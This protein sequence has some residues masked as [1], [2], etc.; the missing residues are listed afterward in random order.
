MD[1]STKSGANVTSVHGLKPPVDSPAASHSSETRAQ[2]Y[3]RRRETPEDAPPSMSTENAAA[4][5]DR[6]RDE[7]LAMFAHELRNAIAP[8]ANAL[9]T[10]QLDRRMDGPVHRRARM[11]IER[12][13]AHLTHLAD[14]LQEVSSNGNAGMRLRHD[15]VDLRAVVQRSVEAVMSAYA[16]RGHQVNVDCPREPILVDADAI[17]LEQVAVNV[18]SNAAKYTPNGGT[19]TVTVA[20]ILDQAVLRVSDTGIGIPAEMLSRVFDLFTRAEDAAGHA[21]DGLGI[22]LNVVKR[23]V[24]LHHGTVVALS[25]GPGKGTEFVVSL[26]LRP[27][28]A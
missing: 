25:D 2:R 7:F 18:L 27:S 8:V 9:A 17:K 13:I 14:D 23:I 11:L 4:V 3:P 6:H 28:R 15:A 1:A 19:I 5:H 21:R 10:L 12:Q 16:Q 20:R 22:G 24:D 26:P